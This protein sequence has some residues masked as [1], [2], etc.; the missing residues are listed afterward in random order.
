MNFILTTANCFPSYVSATVLLGAADVSRMS[1]VILASTLRRHPQFDAVTFENDI[2]LL[3]LSHAARLNPEIQIVRLP[4]LRQIPNRFENF[5]TLFA[6]WGRT[7]SGTNEAIPT[8]RL[9]SFRTPTITHTACRVRFPSNVFDSTIC[10]STVDG[11][12][13]R[14]DEGSIKYYVFLKR[15]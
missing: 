11:S 3:R 9:T 5:G 8:Q 10:T 12:P 15:L 7:N 13:C 2:A 1:D 6:G 4:N 14:G